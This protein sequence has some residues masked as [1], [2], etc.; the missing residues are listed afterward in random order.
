[1]YD[2]EYYEFI[3]KTTDAQLKALDEL[4]TQTTRLLLLIEDFQNHPMLTAEQREHLGEMETMANKIDNI[5]CSRLANA[6]ESN[7]IDSHEHVD[8]HI[9]LGEY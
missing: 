3:R 5:Q 6:K 2:E 7:N 8:D 1:M 4:L 9:D